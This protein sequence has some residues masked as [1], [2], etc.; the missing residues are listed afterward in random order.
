[1][2]GTPVFSLGV[3]ISIIVFILMGEWFLVFCEFLILMAC[4]RFANA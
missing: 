1:M 3:V 4:M 2:G